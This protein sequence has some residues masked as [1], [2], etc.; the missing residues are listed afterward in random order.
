MSMCTLGLAAEFRE[1]GIAVNSLWPKTTVDSAAVRNL[2]PP[3]VLEASRKPSIVA[4]A[5]LAILEKSAPTFSGQ[6]LL[7]EDFLRSEGV[8]DFSGYAVNPE[9]KK[10]QPDLYVD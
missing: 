9:V 5:A 10:L 7:D 4:D 2:F 6:F 3:Q 1:L 8:S